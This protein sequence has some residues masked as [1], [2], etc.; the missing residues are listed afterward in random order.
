[1]MPNFAFH[2]G[3][4][5][6]HPIPRI[7]PV[8]LH[9]IP[10]LVLWM[11]LAR[12]LAEEP[13]SR[14]VVEESRF[15][16]RWEHFRKQRAFPLDEIPVGARTRAL[17]QINSA[18]AKGDA[19][20]IVGGFKWYNIGPAP[21]FGDGETNVGRVT[22]IAVDPSDPKH[23]LVGAAQGGVWESFNAGRSWFP[24]TDN[25]PSLATGCILFAPSDPEVIYVG[26]GEGNFSADSYAGAGLI[27]SVNGGGSWFVLAANRFAQ[28][29][30]SDIK[31]HQSDPKILVA[32]TTRG[33]LGQVAAGTNIPPTAPA[34]GFFYSTSGGTNWTQTL[35]GEGTD[36]EVDPANFSRQYGA[37][38]EIYGHPTNG[39]YRSTDSGQTWSPING[40]WLGVVNPTNMGRIELAIAPSNPNRI[41][42]SVGRKR[43][44]A[45]NP[46]IGIWRTDNAWAGTPTWTQIGM[47]GNPSV[48]THIW[49]YHDLT[50][51][52]LDQNILYF[53]ELDLWRYNGTTW[54]VIQPGSV[55]VDFHALAWQPFGG[56]V[57]LLV[58]NDGGI[59]SASPTGGSWT[60]HNRG[61][62]IAQFYEG[63]IHPTDPLALGGTQDN[64]TELW[65]G[66]D[67][68][69]NILGGDGGDCAISASN[70]DMH[71]A[72]SYQTYN[73]INIKRTKNAGV[74]ISGASSGISSINA[75]FIVRFEKHFS[76]DDLFIAGTVNVWK[77]VNFFSATTPTW[78]SNSPVLN[79]ANGD[80]AEISALAFAPTDAAG[81]TYAYGTED[82]Q[83]RLTV[84]GGGNWANID[85]VNGVPNRY[86]TDLAFDPDSASVLYVTLSGFDEGTPGAPG[87]VFKTS[88][89]L[90]GS[91]TWSNVSPPVNIPHNAII[92]H[93]S[94]SGIVYVGTDLGVWRSGSGGN[95]WTHLGPSSGLPNV[96][97]FELQTDNDGRITAFTHGRGAFNYRPALA[98]INEV[99]CPPPCILGWVN[100]LDLVTIPVLL[101]NVLPEPTK[102]LTA[103]LRPTDQIRPRSGPQNYGELIA[104]GPAVSKSFTFVATSGGPG[105]AAPAAGSQQCGGIVQAILDLEDN[106][107]SLGSV[108]VDLHLGRPT[109]PVSENFEL[110]TPPL[111]PTGWFADVAGVGIPWQTTTNHPPNIVP[112]GSP[113]K[114]EDDPRREPEPPNISVFARMLFDSSDNMLYSPSIP[115]LTAGA[116]LSF[117]HAFDLERSYDGGVLEIALGSE[118]FL[119]IERAQ[120]AFVDNGYNLL[121]NPNNPLGIRAAWSGDSSGW[122]TTLVR[123]PARAAGMNVRLRWRCVSD[124]SVAS[125]GWYLD[126]ISIT[127]YLCLNPVSAPVIVRPRQLR[128]LFAF[129]FATVSGRNYFVECT[130]SL[131]PPTWTTLQT[132]PGD[133]AEHTASTT[134]GGVHRFYRFRVE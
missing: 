88:N 67:P 109:V 46:L 69:E 33:V 27:K 32:A 74:N 72:V 26:T 104:G 30:I 113:D 133:G 37:L 95:S 86:V 83:L 102:N 43:L 9:T 76:N 39:V 73:G 85:A 119:D 7:I 106:G 77:C 34:R 48:S 19:P 13:V 79:K 96:A 55:H 120:G 122:I 92:T 42:V 117:R 56:G 4:F 16:R 121:L 11:T 93:P 101:H 127:E 131:S 44:A 63:A 36:L 58:G 90:A 51:N 54:S 71:W 84:N 66:D 61:L 50:V 129:S 64:G 20:I 24:Q 115:I 124:D 112:R 118:P 1:M 25:Q 89:A 99:A 116:E 98:W 12:T 75:P 8:A 28:S 47:A 125:A 35:F 57:R 17:E 70:P 132:I 23:W 45:G 126:D 53:G 87:H 82:G 29:S 2:E 41:Y 110:T 114:V 6:K 94:I 21:I 100:P 5:M 60:N 111:L 14:Q 38:G 81:N 103:R 62:S 78:A 105:L 52:P 3:V 59:W 80:P 49:Y 123:L 134:S 130:D 97:V 10:L 22:S 65:L 107:T 40:P 18:A 31:V 91:P 108:T 15:T 128:D 68:W